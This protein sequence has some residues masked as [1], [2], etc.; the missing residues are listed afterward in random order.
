MDLAS[1]QYMK[2]S[3]KFSFLIW[4]F[5]LVQ[6]HLKPINPNFQCIWFS[7][8]KRSSIL[9][10]TSH[11]VILKNWSK[12][13][14]IKLRYFSQQ[15][16]SKSFSVIYQKIEREKL[17]KMR[18]FHI[19]FQRAKLILLV[20]Y[21][22]YLAIFRGKNMF[23]FPLFPLPSSHYIIIQAE[24]GICCAVFSPLQNN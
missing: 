10:S 18:Y 21:C 24:F 1:P 11:I 3:I 14:N 7:W 9:L 13:I 20:K 23:F 6:H 17:N 22:Q 4:C 8:W 2:H 16:I 19:L 12:I 15:K 5:H